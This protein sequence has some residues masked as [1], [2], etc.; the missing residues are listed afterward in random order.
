M[1]FSSIIFL[2]YFLPLFL[3]AFYATGRSKYVVLLFSLLFYAWGEPVYVAL[4][5]LLVLCNFWLGHAIERVRATPHAK[6]YLYAGIAVN[7]TPLIFFKYTHFLS[8]NIAAIFRIADPS[9]RLGP[10]A[11]PLGISFYTF[12]AISYLVDIYRGDAAA[13]RRLV[14]LAVYIS[15]FPQLIAGPIIRYK[16]IVRELHHP[17]V[18]FERTAQGIRLLLIGLGQKVLIANV[19]AVPADAIFSFSP[20]RISAGVAWTGIICYTLQIYYD[21]CGYSNMAIGLGLL[22]GLQFPK[23]FDYPY[24]ATSVTDFWRRWHITLSQWFRDY[25]YI[26]LGGN[27]GT[28]P[29]TLRNLLVVFFLCGFWHGAGW[30]F[31]GWGALH[32]LFLIIEKVGFS[33]T[34][35][36]LP[37]TWCRVYTMAVVMFGWVLFRSGTFTQALLYVRSLAGFGAPY[38]FGPPLGRFLH[39][40]VLIAGA[41]GLLAAGP[42]LESMIRE[43]GQH[44]SLVLVRAVRLAAL[45]SM[46]ASSLLSLAGGSYNPFIY[47]RF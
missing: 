36:R 16:N 27:R 4:M 19:V 40:D 18:S 6:P 33:T 21:F 42:W 20:D 26:P 30:T 32:G 43:A 2:C 12:H 13:E 1:V 44:L 7:L 29:Q 39:N 23:N 14:N 28:R 47:F 10:L 24:A 46:L 25:L 9:S 31:V 8:S 5:V 41:V 3:I 37:N 38:V 34:L 17:V 11:L 35:K 15:M 22:I 45:L